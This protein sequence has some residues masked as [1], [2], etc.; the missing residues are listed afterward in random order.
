MQA[1]LKNFKSGTINDVRFNVDDG[2]DVPYI[3]QE[4]YESLYED[5]GTFVARERASSARV[6]ATP[7]GLMGVRMNRNGAPWSAAGP[8]ATLSSPTRSMHGERDRS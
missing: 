7:K 2:L 6:Q 8:H 3:E 5:G 1:E 4:Q